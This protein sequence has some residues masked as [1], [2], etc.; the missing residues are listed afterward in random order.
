[1]QSRVDA[2]PAIYEAF[3]DH[4]MRTKGSADAHIVSA[5]AMSEQNA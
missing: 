3:L 4:K 2:L 5:H 1:M